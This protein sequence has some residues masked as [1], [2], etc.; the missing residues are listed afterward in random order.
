MAV[1]EN[2]FQE[3]LAVEQE[4]RESGCRAVC[5]VDEAG[6]G[7]LAGPLVAAAVMVPWPC[8]WMGL[9]DSKKLTPRSR[10]RWYRVI[11]SLA[12]AVGVGLIS[13]RRID[14]IGLQQANWEAMCSAVTNLPVAPDHVVVDGPWNVPLLDLPQTPLV[15]GD[16][17]AI[18]VAA[19]SVVAKVTR[20][21]MMIRL[22]SEFPG[23][24]FA[25]HKGYG[26]PEHLSALAARGPCRIHRRSFHPVAALM[27]REEGSN[28]QGPAAT[29]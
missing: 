7:P 14:R 3:M 24:G 13:A 26:T 11:M 15:R 17:R 28:H 12:A 23:Y 22:D 27:N 10:E 9:T 16:G 8:P 18:S 6:R 5:G 2:R 4:L 29:V 20:D 19:A 1:R 25:R 21:R